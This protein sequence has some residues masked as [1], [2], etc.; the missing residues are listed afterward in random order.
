MSEKVTMAEPKHIGDP[1]EA[2]SRVITQQ[3]STQAASELQAFKALQGR[4]ARRKRS[5]RL[6]IAIIVVIA[7]IVLGIGFFFIRSLITPAPVASLPTDTVI[8]GDYIDSIAA[9]GNL[10]AF[11]QVTITPEVDGTVAEIYF[12]EGDSVEAGQL[13]FTLDNPDLDAAITQAQRGLDSA[14]LALRGAQTARND[15]GSA[16]DKAWTDY[17]NMKKA[18]EAAQ[19]L[20]PTLEPDDPLLATL[21]TQ[22]DVDLTYTAYKAASSSLEGAK[23]SLDSANMGVSDAQAAVD[24]AIQ[25]ADKRNVYAPISGQVVVNNLERG[26]KLSTLASMGSV[27]M[28]IADISRMRMTISINEIDILSVKPGMQA[29]VYVDALV[30]YSVTAEVLRVAS[31]AGSGSESYYGPSGGLVYYSVDLLINNPDPRLKIGM[32]A[33]AEIILEELQN[34]LMVNPMAIQTEAD[35]S[36]VEVQLEDGS[37]QSVTVKVIASNNT[38]TVVEGNLKDGDIVILNFGSDTSPSS[39]PGQSRGISVY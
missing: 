31:T 9:S 2:D 32:S 17:T 13:L 3:E 20:A 30:G 18:Y 24:R 14:N 34:V 26:T 35:N 38:Y 7:I 33:D 8:R 25:L 23:L 39:S 5:R 11:E 29:I 28:Q 22:A 36:F 27:P 6:R 10:A 16:V 1:P 37:V 12:S 21:P 15:A 4:S 19:A